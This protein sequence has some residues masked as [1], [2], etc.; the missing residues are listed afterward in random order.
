MTANASDSDRSACLN[1]GMNDHVAADRS[2]HAVPHPPLDTAAPRSAAAPRLA[3]R[4]RR[5]PAAP[6]PALPGI[7]TADGLGG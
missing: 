3:A 4:Q 1:A 7:D 2:S 5:R 6:L